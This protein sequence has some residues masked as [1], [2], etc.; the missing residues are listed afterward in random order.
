MDTRESLGNL[1]FGKT[2]QAILGLLFTHPDESY[3]LRLMVRLSGAGLGPAQRELGKLTAAGLV[4]REQ[5]GRQVSYQANRQSP[6]FEELRGL[7]IKTAGLVDVLRQVLEPLGR[8]IR[9]AFIF[10]SF[11][12]GEESA[13]SDI[14]VMVVGDLAMLELGKAL[15]GAQ[16]R[17]GREVN[18]TIY[19]PQEMA[20]KLAARHHFVT[21]VVKGRKIFLM[22]D[23]HD[24]AGMAEEWVGS[25]SSHKLRRN[26]QP[27][28]SGRP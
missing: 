21:Q 9:A 28:G 18:V 23:E 25:D 15:A 7:V 3:H 17:L 1:L 10:G 19:P 16:R 14:D 26:R 5:R 22:G 27:A 8:R 13:A 20:K 11:A 4:R 24:L 6:I 2:R 12:R